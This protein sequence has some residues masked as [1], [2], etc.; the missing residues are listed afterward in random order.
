[1]VPEIQ[2]NSRSSVAQ[3]QGNLT[4][5]LLAK[6]IRSQE[7]SEVIENAVRDEILTEKD[8]EILEEKIWKVVNH[9]QL[10]PFFNGEDRVLCEQD[11]LV[12]KGP[13]LRPDRINFSN[14]GTVSI[15]DYKTGKPK[16]EDK[17]Q[18]LTYAEVLKTMGYKSIHPYLVY[19]NPEILVVKMN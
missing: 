9:P 4:H 5:E 10:N 12:P 6:V 15:L 14:S 7:V 3:K 1:L 19:L 2:K 11:L 18:I 8:K 13:T 16:E 17:K